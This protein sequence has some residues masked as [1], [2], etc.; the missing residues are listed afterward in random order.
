MANFHSYTLPDGERGACLILAEEGDFLKV[1]DVDTKA[2]L[3]FRPEW[4]H[5]YE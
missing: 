2:V 5:N 1:Y 4:V 3:Y